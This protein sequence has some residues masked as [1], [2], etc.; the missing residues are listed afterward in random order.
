[1]SIRA[2]KPGLDEEAEL[3]RHVE[4]FLVAARELPSQEMAERIDVVERI[5]SFLAE[6][7]LP[8]AAAEQRV[9]YP[10]A[11]RLLHEPDGS[12]DVAYDRAAVR[13][14]LAQLATADAGDAGELQEILYALYAILTAHFWREEALYLR[15]AALDDE[16]GV[17]AVVDEV[18][19]ARRR[20]RFG[21]R[22]V[23]PAVAPPL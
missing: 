6:I 22:G 8:H 19:A 20:G 2:T 18:T 3:R 23:Q 15:L 1:M 10:G 11:A 17:H 9:L 13:R 21:P 5:T 16:S 12:D 4:H 7:L 14:L